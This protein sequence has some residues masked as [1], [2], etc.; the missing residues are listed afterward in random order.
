MLMRQLVPTLFMDQPMLV[1]ARDYRFDQP[2]IRL[3]ALA[4]MR[5]NV[6]AI[7]FR[8]W[9]LC[10]I[11]RGGLFCRNTATSRRVAGIFGIFL[12]Q[13][14]KVCCGFI[15]VIFGSFAGLWRRCGK[16]G[17]VGGEG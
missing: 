3:L 4:A 7:G 2:G 11:P 15:F 8:C 9:I 17:G 13:H 14:E 12:P 10:V 1:A 5:A 16:I 6:V